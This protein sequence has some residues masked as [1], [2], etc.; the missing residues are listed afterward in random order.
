MTDHGV[1]QYMYLFLGISIYMLLIGLFFI[2][3]TT[4]LYEWV[5]K[6]LKQLKGT[7]KISLHCKNK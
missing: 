5:I 1:A 7:I 3:V 4:G 6:K 2:C